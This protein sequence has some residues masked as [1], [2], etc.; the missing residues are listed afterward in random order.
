[1]VFGIVTLAENNAVEFGNP[2]AVSI[3]TNINFPN[4]NKLQGLDRFA[5]RLGVIVTIPRL[6]VVFQPVIPAQA[7]MTDRD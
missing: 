7:G 5:P 3:Q 4:A 1:M 6:V 2:I